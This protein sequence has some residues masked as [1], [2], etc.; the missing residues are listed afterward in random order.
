MEFAACYNVF[1]QVACNLQG[2]WLAYLYISEGN[3][4]GLFFCSKV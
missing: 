1:S 2:Q 3:N 4:V